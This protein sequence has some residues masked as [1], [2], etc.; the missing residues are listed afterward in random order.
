MCEQFF[1]LSR[2]P[3]TRKVKYCYCYCLW[4]FPRIST[5]GISLVSRFI[6]RNKNEAPGFY[7]SLLHALN[8]RFRGNTIWYTRQRNVTDSP[9]QEIKLKKKK[10]N[11]GRYIVITMS[12]HLRKKKSPKLIYFGFTRNWHKEK[13]RDGWTGSSQ[14][15]IW[16]L[17]LIQLVNTIDWVIENIIFWPHNMGRM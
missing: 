6:S 8:S 7:W 12:Y 16:I 4:E 2:D 17:E 3:K 11:K 13:K 1:P 5:G 10:D 14:P 9:E 15:H